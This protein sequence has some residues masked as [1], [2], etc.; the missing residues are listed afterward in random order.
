MSNY[1]KDQYSSEKPTPYSN[2]LQNEIILVKKASGE[3][4]PFIL[5]KLAR[6]LKNAGADSSSIEN[7]L[8]NIEEWIFSGV[9]TRQIYSRAFNLL[10]KERKSSAMRYKLKQ[11]IIEL[12]PTGYPF[13]QF[14]GQIFEKQGCEI[15]VGVVVEGFFVNHEMDVVATQ[16]NIQHLVECKYHKDQGKNVSIQ[17]PLYVHSRVGDIVHKR[18]QLP[19]YKGLSFQGWLITNTRFS[20]DSILYGTGCGLNLLAWDYP[21]HRGL[22]EIVEELRLYPV[23]IL[24]NLTRKQKQEL[25]NKGIVTCFQLKENKEILGTISLSDR[26]NKQLMKELQ[27]ICVDCL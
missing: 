9:T 10:R 2:T 4:E 24:H 21:K 1:K 11:A 22:K 17:V 26:K 19:K 25:L 18:N 5:D 23:T 20:E 27:D 6:S 3:E 8:S 15:N 12:G 13:E 7:I 14:I 16:N